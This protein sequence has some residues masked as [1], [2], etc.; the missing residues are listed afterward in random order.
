MVHWNTLAPVPKP[1]IPDVGE[2]GEVIVPA[3]EINVHIPLPATAVFPANVAV[4]PH[5][6]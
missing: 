5:T 1:V 4:V 6:V 2:E 3:P